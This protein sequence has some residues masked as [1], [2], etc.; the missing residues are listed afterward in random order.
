MLALQPFSV[1]TG[2]YHFPVGTFS[3]LR[4]QRHLEA[5]ATEGQSSSI[6]EFQIVDEVLSGL[7]PGGAFDLQHFLL[8][9]LLL[10]LHGCTT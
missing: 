7:S 3:S 9:R 8:F 1:R 6:F 2:A 10:S 5:R 4:Q